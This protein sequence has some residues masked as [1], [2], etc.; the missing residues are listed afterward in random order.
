MNTAAASKFSSAFYQPDSP[1]SWIWLC[2]VGTHLLV[3]TRL[4]IEGRLPAL[5]CQGHLFSNSAV[6]FWRMGLN[7]FFK[8]Q[9]FPLLFS[10]SEGYFL[11]VCVCV[12]VCFKVRLMN[13]T[14]PTKDGS[15][16]ILSVCNDICQFPAV[17]RVAYN[18]GWNTYQL[19]CNIIE[20]W[21]AGWGIWIEDL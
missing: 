20:G 12:C 16:L 5:N 8:I 15:C 3:V 18:I 1:S 14:A 21:T 6:E 17:Q 19:S 2:Y 9:K 7:C 13:P 10:F 4:I 11:R